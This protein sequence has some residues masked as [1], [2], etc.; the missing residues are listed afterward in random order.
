[1]KRRSKKSIRVDFWNWKLAP[2][3]KGFRYIKKGYGWELIGELVKANVR[4]CKLEFI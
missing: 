3:R 1:M 4:G 2:S